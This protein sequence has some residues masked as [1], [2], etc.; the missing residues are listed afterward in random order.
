MVLALVYG[1]ALI[2]GLAAAG[3][4][5]KQLQDNPRPAL[6]ERFVIAV[7][8]M[9]PWRLVYWAT[10]RMVAH[11]SALPEYSKREVMSLTVQDLAIA[12][13]EF[14]PHDPREAAR[15]GAQLLTGSAAPEMAD[16]PFV[17]PGKAIEE[18]PCCFC[19]GDGYRVYHTCGVTPCDHCKG[20][21]KIIQRESIPGP[22]PVVATSW[23]PPL[24]D[25]AAAL[26]RA[27][28]RAK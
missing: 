1:L 5:V 27:G 21:G 10:I 2:L 22:S 24:S 9:L 28:K 13:E 3:W 23:E 16:A 19:G 26:L 6:C 7:A 12:G 8:Y 17:L 14:R 15:R 11:V 25:D 20:T 4:L 18:K